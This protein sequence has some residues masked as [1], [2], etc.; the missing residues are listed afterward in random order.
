MQVVQLKTKQ[1]SILWSPRKGINAAWR[2]A[3][4]PSVV[5]FERTIVSQLVKAIVALDLHHE[6]MAVKHGDKGLKN[7]DTLKYLQGIDNGMTKDDRIERRHLSLKRAELT[8]VA[9][10]SEID[11]AIAQAKQILT[12]KGY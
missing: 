2:I 12:A 9:T 3:S 4:K 6:A 5:Q 8:R 1:V 11:D 10:E 7:Y